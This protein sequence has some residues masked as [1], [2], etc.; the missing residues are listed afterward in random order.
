MNIF[1]HIYSII[2]AY[3]KGAKLTAREK[4]VA[5]QGIDAYG[6]LLG[7]NYKAKKIEPSQ[8]DE[9]TYVITWTFKK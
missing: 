3:V 1:S 9:N 2:V 6:P 5:D 8:P 4:R 7:T